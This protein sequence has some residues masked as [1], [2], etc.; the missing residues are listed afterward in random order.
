MSIEDLQYLG[1]DASVNYDDISSNLA[2]N[3]SNAENQIQA[4]QG[5][6]AKGKPALY[7]QSKKSLFNNFYAFSGDSSNIYLDEDIQQNNLFKNPSVYNLV[8]NKKGGNRFDYSDFAY[9]AKFGEIPNNRL[10]TLRRF[11]YPT[12]DDIF[13]NRNEP[14]IGRLITWFDQTDNKLS[15]LFSMTFGMNWKPLTAE[16]ES[17]QQ[18][19]PGIG[20]SGVIG[21]ILDKYLSPN[22]NMDDYYDPKHDSNKVY[23][24]VDSINKTHIRD[25]GLN[26]DNP[27]KL[28]FYYEL[29]SIDG[30]NPKTAFIDLLSH[31]LAVTMNDGKFWG[32]SRY[33]N[34]RPPSEYAK[35]IRHWTHENFASFVQSSNLNVKS[36]LGNLASQIKDSLTPENVIDLA[37]KVLKN[38]AIS[39]ALD[40]AGR[41]SVPLMNSLLTNDPVGEWHLTVGNPF[42]PI[43]VAGNLILKDTKIEVEDDTLGYDD[44]PT[45]IVVTCTLDHA[46]PRDRAG[47]EQMFTVGNGR[48]YW[49]PALKD[50]EKIT[51]TGKF[52]KESMR[53]QSAT[54]I[55]IVGRELYSFAQTQLYGYSNSLQPAPAANSQNTTPATTTQTST[56][57]NIKPKQ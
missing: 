21:K 40:F 37:T 56:T 30:I 7:K 35:R 16:F 6:Q 11:K 28:K 20:Y 1:N 46:M 17:M 48:T 50:F 52:V 44:F 13:G 51:R 14:D 2:E 12:N 54:D 24:P 34:G 25:V 3:Y 15:S 36:L 22:T 4:E 5:R 38:M 29:R 31:I 27:I 33:W 32:G 47:I 53:G 10:I 55:A 18:S 41:A 23:G 26:F 49:K 57:A 19:S 45:K 9:A 42:R 39:K 8:N 43:F